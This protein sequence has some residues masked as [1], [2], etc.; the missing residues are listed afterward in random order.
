[1]EVVLKLTGQ[2]TESIYR[3]CAIVSEAELWEAT[4]KLMGKGTGKGDAVPVDSRRLT[5]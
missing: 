5:P 3:R 1:V 2:R 4:L